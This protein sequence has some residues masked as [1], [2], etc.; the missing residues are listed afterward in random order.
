MSGIRLQDVSWM[1]CK[2][3]GF[4]CIFSYSC[5]LHPYRLV[6]S[7][8]SHFSKTWLL[9]RKIVTYLPQK[10]GKSSISRFSSFSCWV[11]S[12]NKVCLEMILF[13]AIFLWLSVLSYQFYDFLEDMKVWCQC[14]TAVPCCLLEVNNTVQLFKLSSKFIQICPFIRME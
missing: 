9:S 8:F 4:F 13:D 12:L 6:E 3:F 7:D 2:Y 11:S 1:F 10:V 5:V 14:E